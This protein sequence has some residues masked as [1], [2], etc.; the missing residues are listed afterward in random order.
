MATDDLIDVEVAYAEPTRQVI[1]SLRVSADTT[2]RD[3][4]L[5]S[6][7]LERFPRI[8]L[9]S[10]ALGVFGSRVDAFHVLSQGDRVEIY[11]PLVADPKEARRRRA[12]R[13]PRSRGR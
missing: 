10:D 5:Q 4:V 2:A 11:R 13:K 9:V 3:A 7:L 6:G 1:V 12:A 8:N